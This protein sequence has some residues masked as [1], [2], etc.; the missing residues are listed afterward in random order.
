MQFL[1]ILAKL[2]LCRKEINSTD[3]LLVKLYIVRPWLAAKPG[4]DLVGDPP[5]YVYF[6]NIYT[7]DVLRL[8]ISNQYHLQ[9]EYLLVAP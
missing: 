9:D 3:N 7:H 6:Q 8:I 4:D 1:V 5:P 2:Y